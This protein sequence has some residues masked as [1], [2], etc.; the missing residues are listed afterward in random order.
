MKYLRVRP[1]I[2]P[3]TFHIFTGKWCEKEAL[4]KVKAPKKE[5]LENPSGDARC[6]DK[7]GHQII[8]I[9]GNVEDHIPLLVHEVMHA[10]IHAGAYIGFDDVDAGA[11]F[12]AYTAHWLTG[13]ILKKLGG[14]KGRI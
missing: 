3:L 1:D 10:T 2:Y 11:E 12:Y 8:W 14:Y 7:A 13:K 5:R 4:K 6:W 9:K